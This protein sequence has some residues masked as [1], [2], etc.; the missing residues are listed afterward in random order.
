MGRGVG[1]R[2]KKF[3]TPTLFIFGFEFQA[4][5]WKRARV[6]VPGARV[7]Y[8]SSGGMYWY[9]SWR[10]EARRYNLQKLL[11]LPTSCRTGPVQGLDIS[12]GG[13]LL[14]ASS[15]RKVVVLDIESWQEVWS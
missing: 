9:L 12:P 2:G 14:L 15:M 7:E 11:D 4:G 13:R 1:S 10:A 8:R 5:A 6:S 3:L